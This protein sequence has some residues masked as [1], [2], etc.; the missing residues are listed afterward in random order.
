V[1]SIDSGEPVTLK[2]RRAHQSRNRLLFSQ[3]NLGAYSKRYILISFA[4]VLPSPRNLSDSVLERKSELKAQFLFPKRKRE[5]TFEHGA[6][7]ERGFT[8]PAQMFD[9]PNNDGEKGDLRAIGAGV[10]RPTGSLS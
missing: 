1:R 5:L 4:F 8:A 10:R 6:K 7:Q 9:L 3:P 2:G